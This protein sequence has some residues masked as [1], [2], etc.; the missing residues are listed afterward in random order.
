[1]VNLERPHIVLVKRLIVV[2]SLDRL[3]LLQR[4]RNDQHNPSLWEF[5]GGKVKRG[6]DA[7]QAGIEELKEETGLE[8][9][10]IS[11]LVFAES[12]VISKG[13]YEGATYLALFGIARVVG[14]RFRLSEEH[15]DKAWAECEDALDYN[16]TLQSRNALIGFGA[17][18][19]RSVNGAYRRRP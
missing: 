16:L 18:V 2:D 12:S 11:K 1:M 15:E 14:G 7:N 4:S 10:Q 19:I 6:Q 8:V 9:K 13:R 17:T 3:L 5:P